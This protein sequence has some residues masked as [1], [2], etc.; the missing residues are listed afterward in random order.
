[1]GTV[2]GQGR[3]MNA[4]Y[5]ASL[6]LVTALCATILGY[7]LL[8]GAD[9]AT[10]VPQVT[11]ESKTT[12]KA[13]GPV[14]KNRVQSSVGSASTPKVAATAGGSANSPA[15]HSVGAQSGSAKP[16]EA[17]HSVLRWPVASV[18]KAAAPGPSA[19]TPETPDAPDTVGTPKADAERRA[20]L[21][22]SSSG[23][24]RQATGR[25]VTFGLV[26]EAAPAAATAAQVKAAVTPQQRRLSQ[27]P[28][29][30]ERLY[31]VQPGDTFSSISVM[32][33]GSERH[34]VDIAHANPLTD[35]A[36]LTVGEVIRLPNI[37]QIRG[38]AAKASK[39]AVPGPGRTVTHVV[40]PGESLY[41]IADRYYQAAGLW[42]VIFVANRE[43]IG[44]DPDRLL[45]GTVLKI[46][47][48]PSGSP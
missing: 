32:W 30:D 2:G 46:P 45:V 16:T 33:Y 7:Q 8:L 5:K 13:V 23:Q 22:I 35:P 17:G 41:T 47:P 34:W 3:T 9:G 29:K 15:T 43:N 40:R 38:E 26:P 48:L 18:A 42:R 24:G 12:S 36:K 25:T 6:M 1:M 20:D 10:E 19:D 44:P 31:T 28:N 37:D 4:S 27:G 11:V 21:S 14:A 39:A